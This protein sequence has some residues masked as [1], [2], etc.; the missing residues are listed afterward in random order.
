MKLFELLDAYRLI[1]ELIEDEE[2]F[3]ESL[4][5][6]KD[7][8][9]IKI[10]N[11]AKIL[12]EVEY[13]EEVYKIEIERLQKKSKTA[14]NNI[15]FLK[16]YIKC[17]MESLNLTKISKDGIIVS[18][19]NSPQSCVLED[20]TKIPS[21]LKT[22]ILKVP[23]NKL[24]EDMLEYKTDET[25]DKRAILQMFNEGIDVPGTNIVKNKHIRIS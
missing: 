12:K 19:A 20:E 9:Q 1:S 8:T 4:E 22:A 2:D 10:I 3:K 15:N 13:N 17:G 23:L 24:P 21:N 18:L 16:E 25:I 14:Q 11:L 5:N 7:E 6:I